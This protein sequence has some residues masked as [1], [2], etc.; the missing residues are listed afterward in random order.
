MILSLTN[1]ER[2]DT[3]FKKII[4]ANMKIEVIHL[5]MMTL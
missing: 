4:V 2:I 3:G 1:V 5:Q